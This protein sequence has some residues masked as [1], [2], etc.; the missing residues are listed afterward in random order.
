MQLVPLWISTPTGMSSIR[1]TQFTQFMQQHK[2][3]PT[4]TCKIDT[5]QG[6]ATHQL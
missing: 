5:K 3:A 2:V 6:N 4:G 1:T